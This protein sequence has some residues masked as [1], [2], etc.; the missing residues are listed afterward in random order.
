[1]EEK[2]E[3]GKYLSLIG[4]II[5]MTILPIGAGIFLEDQV[6]ESVLT[7]II[8]LITMFLI[9]FLAVVIRKNKRLYWVNMYTYKSVK[10]MDNDLVEALCEVLYQVFTWYTLLIN[11][12]IILGLILNYSILAD[13]VFFTMLV[14]IM[15]IHVYIKLFRFERNYIEEKNNASK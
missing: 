11:G 5:A 4:I 1:M 14:I 3:R 13:I 9:W 7:R 10:A 12:I 8:L 6:S 15:S 2:K